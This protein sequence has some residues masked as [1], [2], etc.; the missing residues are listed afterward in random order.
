MYKTDIWVS[1]NYG[2]YSLR[3][4]KIF[5]L[6]FVPFFG[7]WFADDNENYEN[8]IEFNNNEYCTTIIMYNAKDSSFEVNVRNLWKRG[9]SDE[10][11]D[12]AIEKF[13]ATGWERRDTTN[14]PEL[15]ELM[16]RYQ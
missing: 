10:A 14:I 5:E 15:K 13:T 11:I 9:A 7:M 1:F 8:V 12:Y 16:K 2:A 6:S 4:R 3:F